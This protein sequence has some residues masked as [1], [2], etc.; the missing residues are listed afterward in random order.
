M[1]DD[2]LLATLPRTQSTNKNGRSGARPPKSR[3]HLEFQISHV[4]PCNLVL[5]WNRSAQGA[6]CWTKLD[7]TRVGSP[8]ALALE[9]ACSGVVGRFA[10]GWGRQEGRETNHILDKDALDETS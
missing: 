9:R 6:T 7:P 5:D 2:P 1:L 10:N 8:T 4:K 3:R